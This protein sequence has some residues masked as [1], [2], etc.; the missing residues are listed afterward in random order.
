MTSALEMMQQALKDYQQ[1]PDTVSEED[2]VTIPELEDR[3]SNYVSMLV[4]MSQMHQD[5]GNLRE[6]RGYLKNALQKLKKSTL[7]HNLLE[8][9]TLC[10]IGT[11]FHHLAVQPTTALNPVAARVYPWYYR[12]KARKLLNTALDTMRKVRNTHPNTATILAAIGRLDLE[13]GDL[14]SA[15]LHLVEALDIQTK[16]CGYI[17]PKIALYHQLLAKVASQ[18]G[19]ELSAKSHLQEVDK[20][21]S[22][23]IKREGEQSERADIK[24]PILQKWQKNVGKSLIKDKL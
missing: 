19:D 2:S 16:C 15:K 20:T 21:Y 1:L 5:T 4:A 17:H 7:S 13:S 8:A 11:V 10:T 12:Y 6:A 24:L 3:I 18:N 23:L 14:R 9:K 22:T